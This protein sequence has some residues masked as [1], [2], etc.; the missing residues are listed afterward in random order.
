MAVEVFFFYYSTFMHF[1]EEFKIILRIFVIPFKVLHHYVLR[2]I[3]KPL[4]RTMH[5]IN[6]RKCAFST[7][8]TLLYG[9]V[10]F[11]LCALPSQKDS[12]K[13]N[14]RT[15]VFGPTLITG[16]TKQKLLFPLKRFCVPVSIFY[17][18]VFKFVMKF[19]LAIPK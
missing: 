9:L 6:I 3:S 2:C 5:D 12:F 7:P 17:F 18:F 19:A 13:N 14:A 8:Y 15:A 1:N 10:F 11:Y 16:I 4:T